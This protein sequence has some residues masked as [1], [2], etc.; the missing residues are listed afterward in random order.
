MK[1]LARKNAAGRLR[2]AV[3]KRRATTLP[4]SLRGMNDAD[5]LSAQQTGETGLNAGNDKFDTQRHQQ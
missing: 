1:G 5:G 2:E 4:R 3:T